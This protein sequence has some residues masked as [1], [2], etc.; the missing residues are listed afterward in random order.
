MKLIIRI[1]DALKAFEALEFESGKDIIKK[2]SH[3]SLEELAML[4]LRKSDWKLIIAGHTDNVGNE[5]KN[6]V[7]SKK[8]AES[9]KKFYLYFD[10]TNS[11][12]RTSCPIYCV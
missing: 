1:H 6:M 5:D 4:L 2:V 12:T 9:V 10:I 3:P 11:K 7:L 8:R